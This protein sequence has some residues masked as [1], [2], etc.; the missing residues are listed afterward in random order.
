MPGVGQLLREDVAQ[1]GTLHM[2]LTF[3]TYST[4]SASHTQ[5]QVYNTIQQINQ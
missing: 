4:L 2:K 5:F 1:E 3:S